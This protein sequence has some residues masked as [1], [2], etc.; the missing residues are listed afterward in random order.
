MTEKIIRNIAVYKR[1][2]KG[3]PEE[4]GIHPGATYFLFPSSGFEILKSAVPASTRTVDQN[5][6]YYSTHRTE[7]AGCRRRLTTDIRRVERQ[8]ARDGHDDGCDTGRRT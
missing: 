7:D 8:Q 2:K 6:Y 3:K 1:K 5:Y 4:K